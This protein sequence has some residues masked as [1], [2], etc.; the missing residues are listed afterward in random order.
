MA[1]PVEKQ[2]SVVAALEPDE[3]A[4][5][6]IPMRP[7]IR[8]RILATLSADR[9]LVVIGKVPADRAAELLPMVPPER[10][11][12]LVA[13]LADETLF[14]L[15]RQLPADVQQRVWT[16]IPR[17]RGQSIVSLAYQ[18]DVRAALRRSNADVVVP[19]GAPRG[20]L[21]ATIVGKHIAVA[22]IV[23]DDGWTAVHDAKEAAHRLRTVGALAV[24]DRA[25]A[26]EVADHCRTMDWIDIVTWSGAHD[27]HYLKRSM[28]AVLS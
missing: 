17:E 25:P 23:G 8:Q 1:L 26:D 10:L 15:L 28:V 13:G 11:A 20:I 16:A 2:L 22:T 19:T 18:L 3:L 4:G 27:D 7:D 12:P 5:V 14:A 24:V 6:L 9:L 21:V